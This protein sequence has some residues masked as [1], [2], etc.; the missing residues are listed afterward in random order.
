MKQI[1]QEIRN[2]CFMIGRDSNWVLSPEPAA[3]CKYRHGWVLCS[4]RVGSF[5]FS[6]RLCAPLAAGFL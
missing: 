4:G 3:G 6:C 1:M 2:E 5:D